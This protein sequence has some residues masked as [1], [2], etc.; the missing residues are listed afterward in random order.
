MTTE[1]TN[2]LNPFNTPFE[3]GLRAIC[4]L[5][6]NADLIFDLHHMLAFDHLVV[7]SGDIDGGPD[8]LHI[9]AQNRNGELLIRRPIIENGLN[10]MESKGLIYRIFNEDGI[11]YQATDFAS[12]FLNSMTSN[13]IA[14]LRKRATWAVGLF[15]SVEGS[16]FA[17]VFNVAFDRWTTEFQFSEISLEGR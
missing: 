4:I 9:E 13:Y 16:F 15:A 5:E 17:E 3:T 12:V 10:L 8:S 11:G 1:K 6:A 14:E 7:H 2:H